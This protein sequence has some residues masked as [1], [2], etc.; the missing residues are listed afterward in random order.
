MA[1]DTVLESGTNV[2]YNNMFLNLTPFPGLDKDTQ[3]GKNLINKAFE[4]CMLSL[5]GNWCI[6]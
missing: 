6:F 4:S 3:K 1:R 5:P 2:N